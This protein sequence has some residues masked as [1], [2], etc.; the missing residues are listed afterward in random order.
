MRQLRLKTVVATSVAALIL[1]LVGASGAAAAV[2]PGTAPTATPQSSFRTAPTAQEDLDAAAAALSIANVDDV[3]GNLTL[4]GAP[5]GIDIAWAS[6]DTTVITTDGVVTRP[7]TD[8]TVTL[9]ATL[10]QGEATATREFT[11]TVRAAI[12]TP[13]YEGYAF[14]YFTGNSLAGENI[15]FAASEGNNAL[16]WNELNAGRPVL[17]SDEGT[18]GLRDPFLIRSPEGDTFYLIATDLSI[19]SGTSW[20]DS[21]R[22]GSHYLEVWESHDLVTWSDQRHI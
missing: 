13:D 15:Y 1:P 12:A 17:T 19:G 5:E 4:P 21:V 3:R 11:A 14:A 18:K 6:S 9:T 2:S 20:G 16:D 10:S 7:A 8:T 22:T